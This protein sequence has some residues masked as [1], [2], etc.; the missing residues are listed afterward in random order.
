MLLEVEAAQT[1]CLCVSTIVSASIVEAG[2]KFQ[3]NSDDRQSHWRVQWRVDRKEDWSIPDR[4]SCKKGS[5]LVAG[6]KTS[7]LRTAASIVPRSY[8]S[9]LANGKA[10][11]TTILE[12]LVERMLVEEALGNH[13]WSIHLVGQT[14]TSTATAGTAALSPLERLEQDATA[15]LRRGGSSGNGRDQQAGDYVTCTWLRG[16]GDGEAVLQAAPLPKDSSPAREEPESEDAA[17]ASAS[18]SVAPVG[19]ERR[20]IDYNK[21]NDNNHHHQQQHNNEY[22]LCVDVFLNEE[23]SATVVFCYYDCPTTTLFDLCLSRARNKSTAAVIERILQWMSTVAGCYIGCKPLPLPSSDLV[24]V[25]AGNHATEEAM[26]LCQ[27]QEDDSTTTS[28]ACAPLVLT[29]KT[30]Q[31]VPGIDTLSLTVPPHALSH[32]YRAIEKEQQQSQSQSHHN[33][34][35]AGSTDTPEDTSDDLETSEAPTTAFPVVKAIECFVLEH[36]GMDV[37]QLRLCQIATSALT[38]ECDGRCQLHD[39]AVALPVVRDIVVRHSRERRRRCGVAAGTS[40][41]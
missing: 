24:S 39:S 10:G 6:F 5:R 33:S 38:L 2:R 27:Q 12:D 36:F 15:H 25:V 28:T 20:H 13:T 14:S 35:S 23:W 11:A 22:H 8:Y 16:G 37:T 31:T 29:Y 1:P 41:R 21:N 17:A 40:P 30:Q 19:R 26:L 32:L 9:R 4:V 3:C 34:G 7:L 18:T